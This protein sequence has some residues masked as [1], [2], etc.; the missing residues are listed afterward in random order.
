MFPSPSARSRQNE[1]QQRGKIRVLEASARHTKMLK[2]LRRL[3]S[4]SQSLLSV[5]H[6]EIPIKHTVAHRKGTKC[7]KLNG[8]EYFFF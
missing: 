7:G 2:S 3:P 6:T 1:G 4:A 5:T 8:N